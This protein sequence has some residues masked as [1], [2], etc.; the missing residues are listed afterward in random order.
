VN[1]MAIRAAIPFHQQPK[2]KPDKVPQGK[3]MPPQPATS[4]LRT[5]FRFF[6]PELLAKLLKF[7]QIYPTNK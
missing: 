6:P 7:F 1:R 2:G 5:T 4:A 3:A